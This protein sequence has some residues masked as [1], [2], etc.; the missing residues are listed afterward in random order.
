MKLAKF[1]EHIEV[2]TADELPKELQF[3][4]DSSFGSF[5]FWHEVGTELA[6]MVNGS[7]AYIHYFPGGG[8]PG[9]QAAVREGSDKI[10]FLANNY[11]STPMPKFTT[12]SLSQALIAVDEFFQSG[13]R[14]SA[15]TWESL[16]EEPST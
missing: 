6:L 9:Y 15:I 16:C 4:H 1:R 10:L 11:E 14:P 12:L 13:R 2:T 7:D 3:R 8:H 5:W